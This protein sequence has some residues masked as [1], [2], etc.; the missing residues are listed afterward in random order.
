M[1]TARIPDGALD[2]STSSHLL[3]G[4]DGNPTVRTPA[5]LR[6]RLHATTGRPTVALLSGGATGPWCWPVV[7]VDH[8]NARPPLSDPLG[9][10]AAAVLLG[11]HPP[12]VASADAVQQVRQPARGHDR[13]P[14]ILAKSQRHGGRRLG[15]GGDT[16]GGTAQRLHREAE[17]A[18][19]P[20]VHRGLVLGIP[21]NAWQQPRQLVLDSLV[22]LGTQVVRVEEGDVDILDPLGHK[23]AVELVPD[24][25]SQR[26]GTNPAVR[27]PARTDG[28]EYAHEP[29][30]CPDQPF[31]AD[32]VGLVDG[33][34][35]R[36]RTA[37]ARRPGRTD[38]LT[39]PWPC[40]P[41][42][43]NGGDASQLT[44][45]RQP[46]RASLS[47]GGGPHEPVHRNPEHTAL[48]TNEAP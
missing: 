1:L 43:G 24:Q 38:T 2:G 17:P 41:I 16:V 48:E 5:G 36:T 9:L 10:E 20:Q 15:P 21:A 27:R 30:G 13:Q 44:T 29:L 39:P 42:V 8:A 14:A 12:G 47:A 11:T 33:Q 46:D 34:A 18:L 4:R 3:D 22:P 6:H 35:H 26:A 23:P 25:V 28:L 40:R 45:R 7:G 32:G 19:V 31:Q 37:A